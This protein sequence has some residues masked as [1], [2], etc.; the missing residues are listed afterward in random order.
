M[1]T[2]LGLINL[3]FQIYTIMLFIRILASWVPQLYEYRAMQFV[4]YYTD[5][6]LNLFRRFIPPLGMI[7][8]SPIVAFLCLNFAQNL[9][10]NMLANFIR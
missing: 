4:A 9:V 3:I 7:D 1:L 10:I 5:P 2:V 6:Y 8:F